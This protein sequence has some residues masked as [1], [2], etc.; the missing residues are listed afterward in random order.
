VEVEAF[1]DDNTPAAGAAIAV[2]DPA[3][4]MTIVEGKTDKEGRWSMPV[5]QP[6]RYR[7]VVNAGAG[8]LADRAMTI[9]TSGEGAAVDSP[10]PECPAC[11]CEPTEAVV[12]EGPTRS[13][14][15]RFPWLKAG[16]GVGFLGTIGLGF[17]L[18][19]G[20]GKM[21]VDPP[22]AGEVP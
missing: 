3:R 6:G 15:T 20:R 21:P 13:E 7:V 4:K 9:P 12:S 5:P 14:F 16:I 8:H 17:W 10:A 11:C 2:V 19:R 1:F 18:A 22:P